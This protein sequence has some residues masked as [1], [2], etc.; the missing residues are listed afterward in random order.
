MNGLELS[1]EKILELKEH[2]KAV[3]SGR[4][5]IRLNFLEEGAPELSDGRLTTCRLDL[6]CVHDHFPF[7]FPKS[8]EKVD[9][10]FKARTKAIIHVRY[11]R[12]K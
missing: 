9:L 8:T 7:E 4:P 11:S 2:W 6:S 10:S 5:E 1:P 12:V 3:F